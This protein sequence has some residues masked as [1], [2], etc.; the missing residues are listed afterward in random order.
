MTNQGVI[1]K[2]RKL[3]ALSKSP[4]EHEAALADARAQELL[5]QHNLVLGVDGHIEVR[6]DKL[7][8]L[9]TGDFQFASDFLATR[10]QP[11]IKRKTR[12]RQ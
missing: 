6:K 11:H 1:E 12:R 9:F 10:I 5:Q 8:E 2:I 3:L 7:F 4:N